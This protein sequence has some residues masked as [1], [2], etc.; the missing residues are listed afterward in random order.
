MDSF[1][2]RLFVCGRESRQNAS[3]YF[4][5]RYKGGSSR[6]VIQRTLAGRCFHDRDGERRFVESNQAMLFRHSEDT[7]YGY[8][9][10]DTQVYQL[11]FIEFLGDPAEAAF[12]TIRDTYGDI[13]KMPD[14][15][16]S[17]IIMQSIVDKQSKSKFRDHFEASQLI[18]DLLICLLREQ[19]EAEYNEDPVLE[20][21]E[22]IQFRFHEDICM[23]SVADELGHSREHL[24]RAFKRRY[25]IPPGEMLRQRRMRHA[26][27][28]ISSSKLSIQ[29]TSRRCGYADSN[30]FSRAFKNYFG[31][32]P[33]ELH[34]REK[35]TIRDAKL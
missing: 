26:Q 10:D 5:N 2:N 11:E 20:L 9:K 16:E 1:L 6:C 22:I 13:L 7:Q 33:T 25:G 12:Q 19:K 27:E 24:T 3:Y 31:H 34:K 14:N 8:F 17:A 23:K 35:S 28:L 18:Y 21:R 15:C 4:D 30:V 29:Q 32:S